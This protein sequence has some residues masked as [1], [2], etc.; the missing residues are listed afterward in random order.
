MFGPLPVHPFFRPAC[1]PVPNYLDLQS[2]PLLQVLL[3]RSS[4]D[5]R[6]ETLASTILS[7]VFAHGKTNMHL[8]QTNP[9]Q[10]AVGSLLLLYS[11]WALTRPSPTSAVEPEASQVNMDSECLKHESFILRNG[12]L[13]GGG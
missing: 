12:V 1:L 2:V 5:I 13:C 8:R 9:F 10:K 4:F 11:F 3:K 6:F 7:D